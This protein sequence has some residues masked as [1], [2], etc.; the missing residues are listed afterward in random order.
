MLHYIILFGILFGCWFIF[1]G[2][3]EPF[4]IISGILSCLLSVAIV[5]RMDKLDESRFELRVNWN[6][7]WYLLWIAKEVVL[8]SITVAIRVWTPGLSLSPRLAWVPVSQHN[9]VGLTIYANSITLTPGTVSVS[10]EPHRI[11]VHA[12]DEGDIETLR[13]GVMECRVSMFHRKVID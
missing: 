8:S 3:T 7:P 13:K 11:L 10:A 9:D 2:Y 6:A 1:S 5:Y 4:F 12:L